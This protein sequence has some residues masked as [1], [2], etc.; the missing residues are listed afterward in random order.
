MIKGAVVYIDVSVLVRVDTKTGIQRVVRSI[1]R[2]LFAAE[3]SEFS[4]IPIYR[5]L[6]NEYRVA[7]QFLRWCNLSDYNVDY[8]IE[9]QQNDIYL[10][11]DLDIDFVS[12][13]DCSA[14][15]LAQQQKGVKL[16]FVVYD[17]LPVQHG[18][19]FD[20]LIK[21]QFKVWLD[22]VLM[23]GNGVIGISQSI[24]SDIDEYALKNDIKFYVKQV[25]TYFYL[26]ANFKA[27]DTAEENLSPR[28]NSEYINF[29]MVGTLE[30]RKGHKQVL[31][32]FNLL[33]STGVPV[34]LSL[35]GKSGWMVDELVK[36]ISSHPLLGSQLF[37][38]G[39]LSDAELEKIYRTSNC[40]IVASEGEGFGLPL[41]EAAQ[42]KLPI[43]ARDIPVFRE[44]A[45]NGA[46]Y[47]ENG[48]S[49]ALLVDAIREWLVLYKL[50]TYPKSS[51]IPWLTWG[52][53]T[54][55]LIACLEQII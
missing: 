53:S 10:G 5:N 48:T 36:E 45:G 35:V 6:N 51:C 29:L 22:F 30:P 18:E 12:I 25:R 4:Y 52:N 39:S 17:L 11:L 8:K 27:Y 49:S 32:A 9:P 3:Q 2:E 13:P 15:W 19:W 38:F 23:H 42:Y 37:W 31:E 28:L 50:N 26:G 24:L 44:V 34:S 41:I 7:N 54:K 14:Y 47:F 46:F 33:W 40:L 16:C 20:G 55:Q 21:D 43:I 1:V